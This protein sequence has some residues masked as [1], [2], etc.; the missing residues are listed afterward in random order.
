MYNRYKR[1]YSMKL[2]WRSK[3]KFD[4]YGENL[5]PR[6]QRKYQIHFNFSKIY[7]WQEMSYG[8]G[9]E[10]V[11]VLLPGL[12]AKPGNKTAT[13]SWLDPYK[14]S[15]LFVMPYPFS[16]VRPR[17]GVWYLCPHGKYHN[18]YPLG[19]NGDI[20]RCIFMTEKICTV[21]KISLKF[22]PKGW[23]DNNPALI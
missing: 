2:V 22:V 12:I 4:R 9:H 8:S 11:A 1:L 7:M 5:E 15:S 13:V 18:S 3:G 16:S 6:T 23:I 10:T 19:Q 14:H 21:I 17:S 20:F